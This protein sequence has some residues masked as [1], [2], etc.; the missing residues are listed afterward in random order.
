M[1]SIICEFDAPDAPRC[2]AWASVLTYDEG[3]KFQWDDTTVYAFAD[4]RDAE[5]ARALIQ[6]EVDDVDEEFAKVQLAREGSLL[7]INTRW[8][9]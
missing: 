9:D 8:T 4:G 2:L 3:A 7:A 1:A 5:A 6:E